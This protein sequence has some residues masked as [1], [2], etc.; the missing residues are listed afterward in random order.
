MPARGERTPLATRTLPS[1]QWTC[2]LPGLPEAAAELAGWAADDH[3]VA[4]AKPQPAG[5]RG[6]DQDLVAGGAREAVAIG[7][8]HAVELLAAPGGEPQAGA[9]AGRRSDRHR[10]ESGA[11]VG[12]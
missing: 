3:G 5:I 6:T 9:S 7:L 11:A 2:T 4:F 8:D 1:G 10:S 12:R